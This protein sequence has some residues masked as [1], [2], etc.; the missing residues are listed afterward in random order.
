M[1]L[2]GVKIDI[3]G[4]LVS[5]G[6]WTSLATLAGYGGDRHWFLDLLSHFRMQYL[7]F[8]LLLAA[9][10][11]FRKKY[12]AAGVFALMAAVNFG[13]MRATLWTRPADATAAGGGR[14]YRML[15]LNVHME[16]HRYAAVE[17]YIRSQQPDFIILHE[18]DQHWLQG[19]S[20]LDRDYPEAVR[21]PQTDNYGIALFSKLPLGKTE[22]VYLG[23]GWVPSIRAEVR[24]NGSIFSL[25]A[26]RAPPPR[27]LHSTRTRNDLIY[28]LPGA[29]KR[30]PKPVVIAGDLN[31]SPWSDHYRNVLGLSDL[32]DSARGF[33]YQPTWPAPLPWW[34][35][36]PIDQFLHTPGIHVVA[37]KIGPDLGSDH[38][39]LVVDFTTGPAP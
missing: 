13:A 4:M 8:L 29:I 2:F 7:I 5:C 1:K 18:V 31:I 38:H 28:A 10:L 36:I 20:A 35:R 30:L 11:P 6:V 9:I 37:R 27:N 3:W 15:V 33:G 32:R 19:L 21:K 34:L 26:A 22:L 39:P 12:I 17:A 25:L 16:N 23:E 14:T 24:D